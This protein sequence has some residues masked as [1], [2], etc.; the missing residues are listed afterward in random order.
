M[1]GVELGLA[2][3]GTVDICLSRGKRLVKLYAAFKGADR[4]IEERFTRI[5]VAWIKIELQLEFMNR[6]KGLMDERHQVVQESLV[7]MLQSKLKVANSKIESV[8]LSN[9]EEDSS[10]T[11]RGIANRLPKR[12]KYAWV[13]ESLDKAIEDMEEWQR[14]ADPSWY[15]IMKIADRQVDT[16]LL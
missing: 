7:E 10:G 12:V 3:A 2:I 16:A 8:A 11:E 14:R 5:K 1:S 15:L 9:G 13:K 4:E 6:V